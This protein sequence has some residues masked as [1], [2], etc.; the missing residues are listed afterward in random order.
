MKTGRQGGKAAGRLKDR[1]FGL[2]ALRP[3]SFFAY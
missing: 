3:P 2:Q 1:L